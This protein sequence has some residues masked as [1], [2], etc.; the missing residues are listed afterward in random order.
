MSGAG[1]LDATVPRAAGRSRPVRKRWRGVP[2][3]LVSW[4]QVAPLGVVLLVLFLVPT[5]I[6]TTVSFFDYDRTH[7]YPTFIFDNYA[8]A[9]FSPTTLRLYLSSLKFAAITWAITLFV[10][11]NI[12]YFLIFHIRNGTLRIALFLACAIPFWTSGIIRAI[13]WVPFLGREGVFNRAL[14]GAGITHAPL[15]FLL[16]S[17]F[18]VVVTYVHLFTLLMIGPIANSMSKIDRLVI[19]AAVDAGAG[20]WQVMREIVI[21]LS[22]SG[23]LLG[24]IFVFT[25][26]MGDFAMVKLMSGG[27]SASVVS[28]LSTEINAMQ[29]PPAAANAVLLVIFVVVSVALMMRVVDVRRELAS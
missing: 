9:L 13:S 8:D 16:F 26:V 10:G 17:D 27:R 23:I 25:Q 12:A 29:Y 15:D 19:E 24:T 11:F 21:P 7:L 1:T 3:F 6:F 18:A 20:R 4:A 14:M 28:A 2:A 22:R 5:L